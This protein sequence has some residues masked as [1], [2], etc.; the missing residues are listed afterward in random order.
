[1]AIVEVQNL[2]NANLYNN[3][4]RLFTFLIVFHL[5]INCAY[6]NTELHFYQIFSNGFFNSHF[7]NILIFALLALLSYYLVVQKIILFV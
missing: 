5:L 4:I 3:L 7:C 2:E 1:M 6:Q